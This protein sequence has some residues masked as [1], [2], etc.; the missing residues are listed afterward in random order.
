MT[1]RNAVLIALGSG[2]MAATTLTRAQEPLVPAATP[3]AAAPPAAVPSLPPG[4]IQLGSQP[5][6]APSAAAAP[7]VSIPKFQPQSVTVTLINGNTMSGTLSEIDQWQMKTSLGTTNVPVSAVA[8][9]RMAQEGNATTTVVLHNGDSIT[10]ALQ[11]DNVTIQTDWGR[12]EIYGTH[13]TAITFTPGLKWTSETGLNGTRWKLVADESRTPPAAN[14]TAA[15]P[16]ASSA[17][18]ASATTP[19]RTTTTN[20][21]ATTVV[22]IRVARP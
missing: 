15:R 5:G 11:L 2:L 3:S 7:S 12:A 16:A 22:P 18:A 1:I 20:A 8:G 21:P 14:N 9:V 6:G 13:V 10:G 19:V 17:P 4:Q